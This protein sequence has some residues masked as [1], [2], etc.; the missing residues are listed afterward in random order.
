ML[1]LLEDRQDSAIFHLKAAEDL[2]PDEFLIRDL[3]PYKN[4]FIRSEEFRFW[5]DLATRLNRADFAQTYEN[6]IA[7][8]ATQPGA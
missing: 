2:Y 8:V 1:D 7:Q 3:I 5:S 6:F 4:S